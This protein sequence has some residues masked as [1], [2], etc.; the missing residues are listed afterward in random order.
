MFFMDIGL[1]S[2]GN[3]YERVPTAMY[4]FGIVPA[5]KRTLLLKP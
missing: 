4:S 1:H 3:G 2:F 5:M